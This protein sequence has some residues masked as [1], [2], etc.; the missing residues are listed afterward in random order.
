MD[1]PSGIVVQK[2]GAPHREQIVRHLLRLPADDRRLR[3]G[4]P[5][6]DASIQAYVAGIDFARDGA[7][8]VL[9]ADLE[10][11]GV[12]HLAPDPSEASA[13]LGLSVDASGRGTAAR[14]CN[15]QCCMP[16]TATTACCSCTASPKTARSC[17]WRARRD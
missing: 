13:E 4:G 15:V 11:I 2:L 16:R 12:A 6:N 3:F 5:I 7:F 17:T 14:C 9:A 8:G 10:L 1:R